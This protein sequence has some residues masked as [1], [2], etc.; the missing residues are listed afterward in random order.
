[1]VVYLKR[2]TLLAIPFLVLFGLALLSYVY[3]NE[4]VTDLVLQ[5]GTWDP[6]AETV[7]LTGGLGAHLDAWYNVP[8]S[9]LLYVKN[10]T[11]GEKVYIA[12]MEIKGNTIF[13][14][15]KASYSA[16]SKTPV[17]VNDVTVVNTHTVYNMWSYTDM[18]FDGI[19]DVET[20]AGDGDPAA[21]N[22]F[23]IRVPPAKAAEVVLIVKSYYAAAPSVPQALT[24]SPTRFV[25]GETTSL[26]AS[27]RALK[28]LTT[29]YKLYIAKAMATE[30][31]AEAELQKLTSAASWWNNAD[32]LFSDAT[33][34][35]SGTA[36]SK[37]LTGSQLD[38]ISSKPAGK[39]LVLAYAE[40]SANSSYA[41]AFLEI[42]EKSTAP[43]AKITSPANNSSFK[44]DE[45]V[46]FNGQLL[47]GT[48]KSWSWNFGSNAQPRTSTVQNP[49]VKFTTKGAQSVIL[50]VTPAVGSAVQDSI[51]VVIGEAPVPVE[52][53]TILTGLGQIDE[54]FI[55]AFFK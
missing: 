13:V 3:A 42:A 40:G 54:K 26:T 39:Y 49:K 24:L 52:I 31:T 34:K 22:V 55:D 1:V 15:E 53:N 35:S 20:E 33:A 14:I 23:N 47:N 11:T 46:Q 30:T 18:G 45:N 38:A 51:T 12:R 21:M 29:G 2:K 43:T 32:F 16:G 19:L 36:I 5:V 50:T 48:A 4:T 17:Y 44:V 37:V 25:K 9:F 10:T 27:F 6:D 7:A 41:S 28:D 8:S